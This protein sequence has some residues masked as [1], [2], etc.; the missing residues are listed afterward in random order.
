[1]PF[2]GNILSVL[3]LTEL[4]GG[5]Y[6]KIKK[7]GQ[8][9]YGE[10]WL[11][12][13]TEA[14]EGEHY[15]VAKIPFSRGYNKI[16]Q[17]EADICRKL[18]PHP[19]TVRLIETLNEGGRLILIQEYVQGRTLQELLETGELPPA[20]RDR[21]ILKVIDT[22]AF[23]HR[24]KIM[25]RDIKPNNIMIAPHDTVKLLDYGA[26]KELKDR[27]ISATM[28]GSRPLHGPRADHG[29]QR[30]PER[31]LGPG[32]H[33]VSLVHRR[34]ALLLRSGKTAYRPD[35]HP[36]THSPPDRKTRTCPRN[37]RPSS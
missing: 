4:I 8:G 10:V 26:A 30:T 2:A 28:I 33:H 1:M 21:I 17:R 6:E 27:D 34:P 36:G 12:A 25:H 37:W 22:V 20:W 11:V 32:G 7:L 31:R 3:K 19:G 35:P 15:Y 16:F 23:A 29:P 9:S 5:R 24:L 13:D 14:G 18:A